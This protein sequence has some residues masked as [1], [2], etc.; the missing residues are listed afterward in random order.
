MFATTNTAPVVVA[1]NNQ[2]QNL[3]DNREH[4]LTR[5][6]DTG[7]DNRQI[8]HQHTSNQHHQ[9]IQQQQRSQQQKE[10]RRHR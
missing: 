4:Y 9:T 7:G 6:I 8:D 10:K 2:N 3:A 1:S 5:T